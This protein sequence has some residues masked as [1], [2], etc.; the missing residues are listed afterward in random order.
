MI[1]LLSPSASFSA[2]PIARPTSSTVW[3]ASISRSPFASTIEIEPGVTAELVEH[4]VEEGHAGGGRNLSPLEG[5]VDQDLRFVGASLDA[6]ASHENDQS[7]ASGSGGRGRNDRVPPGRAGGTGHAL[8]VLYSGHVP[9]CVGP[10]SAR[11]E[12]GEDLRGDRLSGGETFLV[13]ER[14]VEAADHPRIPASAA[15]AEKLG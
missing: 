14:E 13:A 15:A 9:A 8:L 3:C 1:P 4:V 10:R 7:T 12:L 2:S 11:S 6:S 5:E